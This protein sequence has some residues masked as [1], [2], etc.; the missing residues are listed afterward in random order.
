MSIIPPK[1]T[2]GNFIKERVPSGTHQAVCQSVHDLGVQEIAYNGETKKQHKCVI[3]WE[4]NE[5]IKEGDFSGQRFVVS[6][7]YTLSL[8]EKATLRHDLAAWRTRDFIEDELGAFDL[9][10][11]VGANCLLSITETTKNGKTFSNIS[12]VM[13]IPKGTEKIV[14]ELPVDHQ[15]KWIEELKAKAIPVYDEP[16]V[17]DELSADVIMG[18]DGV[19]F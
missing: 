10:K 8:H 12:A 13:A 17:Q 5:R 19:P 16:E 15:Y 6:K 18:N 14:P 4:V 9:E 1:P 11:L 3:V 7:R 2:E